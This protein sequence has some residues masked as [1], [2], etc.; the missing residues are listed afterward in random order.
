MPL[1][2]EQLKALKAMTPARKLEAAMQLY[3]SARR[4]KASW[5]RQIHTDWTEEEVQ[6][7]V[8]RIFRNAGT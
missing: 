5:L 6:D 1:V 7:E 4:L 2:S 3:W 8:R